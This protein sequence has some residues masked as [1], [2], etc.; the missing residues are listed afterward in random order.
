MSL[1]N[2]NFLPKLLFL[3]KPVCDN[4][5]QFDLLIKT[6]ND[7]GVKIIVNHSRRFDPRMIQLR[8]LIRENFF[9]V[10]VKI[11]VNYYGGWKNNG[12]HVIDT[13][14]YLFSR[15]LEYVKR[16]NIEN[17]RHLNDPTIDFHLRFKNSLVDIHINGFN[18]EF[19][20]IFEFEFRFDKSRLRIEDFGSRLIYEKILTNNMQENVLELAKINVGSSLL[21]PMENAI[22]II[23]QYLNGN[24]DC[25]DGLTINDISKT[26][27]FVWQNEK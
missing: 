27:Y 6:S 14:A 16:G 3:E 21:S 23:S 11:N 22:N 24:V 12:T 18:E 1:L 9:G 19:Y 5:K 20:Q 10:P 26:M 4:V 13:I 25:I 8:N 15:E 2:H 7:K 17:S